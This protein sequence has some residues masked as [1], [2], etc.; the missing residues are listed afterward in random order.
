M[1]D[2]PTY[3]LLYIFLFYILI[4]ISI[5]NI[6]IIVSQPS[7]YRD[8]LPGMT[9]RVQTMLSKWDY[10]K[11]DFEDQLPSLSKH[12]PIDLSSEMSRLTLDNIGVILALSY[13]ILSILS[14]Y[15]KYSEIDR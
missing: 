14:I 9:E 4:T 15:Y 1:N 7:R 11:Q 10:L 3:S 12:Y 5:S 2:D 6:I 8:S 13:P